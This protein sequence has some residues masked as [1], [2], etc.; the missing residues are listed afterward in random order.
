[1]ADQTQ[2]T[3][4][5]TLTRREAVKRM[6]VLM[7]GALSAPAAA[8]ILSG[9]RA[10]SGADWTPS[11]L[12]EHQ[13]ELVTAIAE[14]IIPETDTPGA[15]AANVNRFIDEMLSK[16][17]FP[18][19]AAAFTTGLDGV[20]ALAEERFGSAFLDLSSDDQVA[21]LTVLDEEAFGPQADF[22][23]EAPPFFRLMKELTVIGYYT[24]EI[25]ASQELHIN[26]V[27]GR[28]D[29]CIPYSEI[30]KAWA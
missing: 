7:G 11:T 14:H 30:G 27:P 16:S 12:T 10:P 24:S 29:G 2:Q 1:M 28:W 17:W 6:A 20:D 15:R 5:S 4:N 13:N 23:P 18:E 25:G 26:L 19:Q 8:G 9:C 21:L 3:M 22:D